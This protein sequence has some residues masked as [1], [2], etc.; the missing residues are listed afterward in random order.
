MSYGALIAVG[1]ASL[2]FLTFIVSTRVGRVEQPVKLTFFYVKE[3]RLQVMLE[4]GMVVQE[5]E[6]I[7]L[8]RKGYWVA[9][10]NRFF[11]N[12]WALDYLGNE[13]NE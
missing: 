6:I 4:S 9:R 10:I 5:G 13:S 11:F 12:L 3:E 1:V 7:G 8:T 2:L